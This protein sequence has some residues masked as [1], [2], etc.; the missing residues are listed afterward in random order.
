MQAN[1]LYSGIRDQYS[2]SL[3]VLK[4]LCLG[5]NISKNY[6]TILQPLS[7][8][9]LDKQQ[10]TR[11]KGRRYEVTLNNASRALIRNESKLK[12]ISVLRGVH[13]N[14]FKTSSLRVSGVGVVSG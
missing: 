9:L 8:F 6:V 2:S 12:T 11:G 3:A 13:D 5:L 1:G 4:G 14:G 7:K 10:T